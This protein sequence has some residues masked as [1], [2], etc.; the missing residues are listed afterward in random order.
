[1][2]NKYISAAIDHGM[3]NS[4]IA[5]IS[6]EGPKVVKIDNR[7]TMPSAVYLDKKNREWVGEAA[8]AA[9]MVGD[10]DKGEGYTGYM[11]EIGQ[12]RQFK[13]HAANRELTAPEL[14]AKVI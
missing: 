12:N 5:Y 14:G 7:D 8:V 3:M 2:S 6:P 4:C 10:R 11:L 13:F 9:M 1:M